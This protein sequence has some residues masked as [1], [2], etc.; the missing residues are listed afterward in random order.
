MNTK[1][2]KLDINKKLYDKIQ[3]KQ[4]DTKSRFLLFHL[5]DGAVQFSLVGRTVRVYGLKPD[6]KEFFN[7]L[8]IV[9]VNKGYCKLE[10]TSQ[11]LAVPGDLDLE[12]V[13]M[14]GESKLSS[15][16]FVVEVIKSLN[17]KSAIE[18]SNEYKALDRS[19]TKVEE[20][21]NE[22][23][24]KSGKLEQLY[25]ER[26]NG[27]GTQLEEK[28]KFE[29]QENFIDTIKRHMNTNSMNL[30]VNSLNDFYNLNVIYD[31][32]NGKGVNYD[33]VKQKSIDKFIKINMCRYGTLS[34]TYNTF[35]SKNMDS[36]TGTWIDTPTLYTTEV[37]STMTVSFTGAKLIFYPQTDDRGGIWE[38]VID[39]DVRNKVTVSTWSQTSGGKAVTI[40]E[41]QENKP[42]TVIATF[43]GDDPDHIPRD[44]AGTSRGWC[45]YVADGNKRPTFD[46]QMFAYKN[47]GIIEPWNAESNK[48][49]AIE[50]K[51]KG[52]STPFYFVPYHTVD[53]TVIKAEP[54]YYLNGTLTTIQEKMSYNNL[55]EFKIVQSIYGKVPEF[56]ENLIQIDTITTFNKNGT[57][58]VDGKITALQDIDINMGY[59]GMLPLATNFVNEVVTSIGNRYVC[60]KTDN[61]NTYMVEESDRATSFIGL[62]NNTYTNLGLA[63]SFNNPLSSLRQGMSGKPI[64]QQRCFINHRNDGKQKIYSRVYEN[65]SMKIGETFRFSTSFILGVFDNLY[66]LI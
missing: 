55:N 32:G 29:S 65:T 14:E 57:I 18:S 22:F 24:D 46:I 40:L 27:L 30:T 7:D 15:I 5:L 52:S 16:P 54:K 35:Q 13:I 63:M 23:A 66:N 37:G 11:A 31:I 56:A 51:K 53:T 34:T 62:N 39:G 49:F 64:P 12:L 9:D 45:N 43:K 8:Q 26:L 60:N 10:L 61:S 25:T 33:L 47:S 42:H 6:N 48:E 3:A 4:G 20:W 2:V 19:L 38:F 50:I 1:I 36:K 58:N 17:S 41:L 59:G 44:G 21:N 28:A